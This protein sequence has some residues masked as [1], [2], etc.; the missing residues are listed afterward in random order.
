MTTTEATVRPGRA[1]VVTVYVI[2]LFQGLAL[3]AFPAAATILTS[4]SGYDLSKTQ[5]GL[6]FIPQVAMAIAGSLALPSLA[7]RFALK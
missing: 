2:G 5:Y 3:V 1:E 4:N 7:R 6:M